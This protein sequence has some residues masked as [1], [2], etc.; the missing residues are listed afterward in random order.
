M[1]QILCKDFSS[2]IDSKEKEYYQDVVE[3]VIAKIKV[4][5]PT[6]LCKTFEKLSVVRR[7]NGHLLNAIMLH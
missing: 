3:P 6:E 1:A 2:P 7:F 4:H 5:I